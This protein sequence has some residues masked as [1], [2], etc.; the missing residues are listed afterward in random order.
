MNRYARLLTAGTI[1]GLLVLVGACAT[2]AGDG[3]SSPSPDP[4]RS[5]PSMT[6]PVASRSPQPSAAPSGDRASGGVDHSQHAGN[7]VEIQID[8][9]AFVQD[10][11]E[12]AVGTTVT[13][14]NGD[15]VGHTI[16]SGADD[17]ADGRFDV[18][19]AAGETFSFTFDDVGEV[20]YFCD[21]HPTMTGLVVV[22]P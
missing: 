12:V 11:I 2:P 3:P 5:V 19:I 15:G 16:T 9:F 7:E 21:I 4:V 14:V 20:P 1:V 18:E 22:T 10:A 8:N 6:A 13:W 17:T